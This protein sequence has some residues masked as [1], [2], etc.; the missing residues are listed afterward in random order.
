MKQSALMIDYNTLPDAKLIS[1]IKDKHAGVYTFIYDK[2]A[3]AIYGTIKKSLTDPSEA[4][5]LLLKLFV[6]CLSE[7]PPVD[8]SC[9]SLFVYLYRNAMEMIKTH[10]SN[11]TVLST[12]ANAYIA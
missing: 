7:T 3:P 12:P 8:Q 10:T 9:C 1:L 2:Y 11:D 6:K 5:A 4:D